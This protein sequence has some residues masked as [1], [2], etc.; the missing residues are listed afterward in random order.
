MQSKP[1]GHSFI[2]SSPLWWIFIQ[3]CIWLSFRVAV[4]YHWWPYF[5]VTNVTHLLRSWLALSCCWH[6]RGVLWCHVKEILGHWQEKLV[7]RMVKISCF[8][9]SWQTMCCW[10][11]WENLRIKK[12]YK[13][14]ILLS[15]WVSCMQRKDSEIAHG[16]NH[17]LGQNLFMAYASL[18][19][20]TQSLSCLGVEVNE[21]H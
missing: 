4:T 19:K 3:I 18:Y 6:C 2:E 10:D 11:V 12:K 8:I 16:S 5:C 13:D 15:V 7:V 17:I 14:V 9:F 20:N 21:W 1:P